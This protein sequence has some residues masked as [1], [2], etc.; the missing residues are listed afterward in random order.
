MAYALWPRKS[1]LPTL[2]NFTLAA[3][4]RPNASGSVVS[5]GNLQ[6]KTLMR[7]YYW[8]GQRQSGFEIKMLDRMW[9]VDLASPVLYWTHFVWVHRSSGKEEFFAFSLY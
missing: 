7:L 6:G 1:G 5:Y 4:V 3:W 2:Q 8:G 9:N